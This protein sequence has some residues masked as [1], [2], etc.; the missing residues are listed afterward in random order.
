MP[1]SAPAQQF[2]DIDSIK[3]D[4]VILKDSSIRVILMCSS[5]NFA[6]K[7]SDEQDA[8]I[9]QYQNFLNALDFPIQFVIHSRRLNVE[10]YLESLAERQ[11][12]EDN[13]L[14]KIQIGEYL[15]FIKT[16]VNAT[17]IMSKTFYAVVPFTP[18]I[19]E[20]EGFLNRT[21]T[22]L[23]ISKKRSA[24]DVTVFEERKTQ[25]WQRAETVVEGLQR[26]GIRSAPLNTEELIE[27]FYGLY[28]PTEF[29]KAVLPVE[30]RAGI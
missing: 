10:P 7:S 5:F 24:S 13:E 21:L 16:F 14:M 20:R 17:N 2:L 12:E 15:E 19:V 25:L 9:F 4:I 8:V 27:L 6:L 18:A 3:E 1:A 23:G 29:E 26:F 30:D 28:N 11:K 22:R